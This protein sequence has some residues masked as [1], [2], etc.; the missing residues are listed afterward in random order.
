M[1]STVGPELGSDRS[2]SEQLLSVGEAGARL[3]AG[4]YDRRR[5]HV[6]RVLLAEDQTMVRRAAGG[7][8]VV[9]PGLAAAALGEDPR[10]RC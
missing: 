2:E 1:T 9:D 7:E 3:P 5:A 6:I 4:G 10:W 8:R